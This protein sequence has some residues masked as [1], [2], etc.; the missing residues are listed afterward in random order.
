MDKLDIRLGT[1]AMKHFSKTPS[2]LQVMRDK[3]N[4]P[5]FECIS[6]TGHKCPSFAANDVKLGGGGADPSRFLTFTENG[7]R[8]IDSLL[9]FSLVRS[10]ALSKKG[11]WLWHSWQSG[12]FQVPTPE[13]RGS[14][15]NIHNSISLSVN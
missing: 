2:F 6:S 9:I 10:Q 4:Q 12:R 1:I 14:N 8:R 15:T 7:A 5:P 11:Q 3:S 13:I